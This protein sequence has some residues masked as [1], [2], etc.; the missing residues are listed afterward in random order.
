MPAVTT[1]LRSSW[2][3]GMSYDAETR[4]LDVDTRSGRTYTHEGVTQEV[5]DGLAGAD[6]PG[7]YYNAYIKGRY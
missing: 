3:V 5:V 6:S 7:E 4:I 2:L 1:V